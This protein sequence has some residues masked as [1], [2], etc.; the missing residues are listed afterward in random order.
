[1][2]DL[3]LK[4]RGNKLFSVR[5]FDEAIKCYTDAIVSHGFPSVLVL[6]ATPQ[7]PGGGGGPCREPGVPPQS[8]VGLIKG[9]LSGVIHGVVKIFMGN[10]YESKVFSKANTFIMD[11]FLIPECSAVPI[12]FWK[13]ERKLR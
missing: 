13:R 12:D 6:T 8:S 7:C 3:E 9:C 5:K 10:I 11:S 4:N 1:M 2:T